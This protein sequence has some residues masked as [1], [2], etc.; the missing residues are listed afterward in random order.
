MHEGQVV[1]ATHTAQIGTRVGDLDLQIA[2]QDATIQTLERRLTAVS[3][4]LHPFSFSELRTELAMETELA[5]AREERGTL[6]YDRSFVL[7]QA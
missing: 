7:R 6:L 1:P 4:S 3:G 2:Q 5:A